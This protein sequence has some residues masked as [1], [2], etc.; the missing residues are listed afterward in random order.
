MNA[1]HLGVACLV[2]ASFLSPSAQADPP[3]NAQYDP[4]T[5]NVTWNDDKSDR[6]PINDTVPAQK[7]GKPGFV[8]FYWT[9]GK[10][11]FTG[12]PIPHEKYNVFMIRNPGDATVPLHFYQ[13][14]DESIT[15]WHQEVGNAK[16]KSSVHGGNIKR[17]SPWSFR[18]L[19]ELPEVSWR[20]PDLA[21]FAG[22]ENL[23]IYTAVNLDLYLRHN[24]LGFF[25]GA[26]HDGQTLSELGLRIVDGQVAGLQGI[27]WSTTEFTF[28]ANSP[29]GWVPLGGAASYLQ[30][31]AFQAAHGDI[32]VLATHA[33][34]VPEPSAWTLLL[35]GL[36]L[37]AI[38]AK[39]VG[40]R[41]WPMRCSYPRTYSP[42]ASTMG[43]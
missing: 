38:R 29:F 42:G 22:D 32:G 33:A 27:Y 13:P 37:L 16:G 26:W 10:F 43:G 18:S 14:G 39:R 11:D 19:A 7:D 36:A 28:D 2:L 34:A 23:T 25:G 35:P 3:Y 40:K 15:D 1:R 31:D 21:P 41:H 8:Q 5:G 12:R 9:E 30:S 24:P 17:D 4:A 6:S 20:I